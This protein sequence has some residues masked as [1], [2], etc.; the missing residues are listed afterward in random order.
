LFVYINKMV[1]KACIIG[2]NYI[3]TENELHGCINDA[4]ALKY[5]LLSSAQ[6]SPNDI[7]VLTDNSDI[8]PTRT[9][10]ENNMKNLVHNAKKGDILFLSYS[11]HG[12]SITNTD[13]TEKNGQDEVLIPV[14]YKESGII[15]DEWLRSEIV[16]KVP[17]G[18]FLFCLFDS[19]H[20]GSILDLQYFFE[21]AGNQ[22]KNNNTYQSSEWTNKFNFG[23]D[24]NLK[25]NGNVIVFS[26]CKDDQTSADVTN[27][28]VSGGAFTNV[29]MDFIREH[30]L[31]FPNGTTVFDNAKIKYREVLKE[32]NAKLQLSGFSQRSV[33]SSSNIE[34]FEKT[35]SL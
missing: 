20:S 28:T 16:G 22:T 31:K 34:N 14:D 17:D 7:T 19:C 27:G 25:C 2:I 21:Y 10:I 35:I 29:F 3:G 30:L 9:N 11:G 24:S 6:H 15:T 4:Q 32:I 13:G 33:L 18:V 12:S 5:F 26:G 8:K 1:K 23:V